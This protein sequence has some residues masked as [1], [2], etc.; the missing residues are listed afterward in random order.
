LLGLVVACGDTAPVL[1]LVEQ[2]LDKV[3]PTVFLAIMRGGS[4]AVAFGGDDRLDTGFGDFLA[5]GVGVIALVR[6]ERLN[7]VGDHSKQRAEAL[8]IVRLAGC[9]DEAERAA[10]CVAPRMEFGGEAAARSAKRLGFLSPLFMP[11]AQ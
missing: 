1:Q 11:T 9:Q 2:A 5:D 8:N 10:F 7:T 6:Q 3:A 4:A